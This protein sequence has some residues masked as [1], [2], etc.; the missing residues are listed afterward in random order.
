MAYGTFS[1]MCID[2][3]YWLC[4]GCNEVHRRAHKQSA[5]VELTRWGAATPKF[6]T[7]AVNLCHTCA[8]QKEVQAQIHCKHCPYALCLSCIHNDASRSKFHVGHGIRHIMLGKPLN[9][10]LLSVYP[11]GWFVTEM[12]GAQPCPCQERPATAIIHCQRCHIL[13]VLCF[14]CLLGEALYPDFD[15]VC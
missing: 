4:P 13:C 1:F 12:R 11:E 6:I 5:R 9:F 15:P 2:C 7:E 10:E 8:P 14:Q 3:P